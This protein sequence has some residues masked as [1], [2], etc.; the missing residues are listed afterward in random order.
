M[1]LLKKMQCEIT[2]SLNSQLANENTMYVVIGTTSC[3]PSSKDK[4]LPRYRPIPTVHQRTKHISA[5]I[6]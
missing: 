2:W 5:L 4:A 3:F 6:S 1:H